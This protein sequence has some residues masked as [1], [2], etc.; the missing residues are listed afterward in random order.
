MS[1]LH[2]AKSSVGLHWCWATAHLYED[3][4]SRSVFAVSKVCCQPVSHSSNKHCILPKAVWHCSGNGPLHTCMKSKFPQ[5]YLQCHKPAV[6]LFYTAALSDKHCIL[7]KAVW[8]CS[9]DG[10]LHTCMKS[11]SPQVYLLCHRPA[12]SLVCTAAPGRGQLHSAKRS[13]G[14]RCCWAT[15]LLYEKQ[16]STGVFVVSQA[17]CQPVLHSSNKQ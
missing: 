10:P 13:L 6:S 2:F 14:L 4:I 1:T 7:P 17:C 11:K 9:G 16:I 15:A 8:H 3:Q 12:V 5:V